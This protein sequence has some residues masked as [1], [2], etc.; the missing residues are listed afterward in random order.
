MVPV[1]LAQRRAAVRG[2]IVY[3]QIVYIGRGRVQ[4]V[5]HALQ[6][7]FLIVAGNDDQSF[8][9]VTSLKN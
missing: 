7:F 8:Q 3:N 1:F 5:Y 6:I 4:I 2:A 9:G